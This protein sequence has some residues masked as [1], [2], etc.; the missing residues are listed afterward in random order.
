[1][2]TALFKVFVLTYEAY[3]KTAPQ[4][5]CV[6]RLLHIIVLEIKRLIIIYE[7]HHVNSDLG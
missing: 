5:V 4:Y 7:L 6:T 3:H 1:M 2:S